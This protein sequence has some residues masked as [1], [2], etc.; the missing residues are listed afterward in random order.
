MVEYG[1]SII[2]L[3][4]LSYQDFKQRQVSVFLL[5]AL[6]ILFSIVAYQVEISW[7]E[8]VKNFVIN[9]GFVAIQI[10]VVKIYF[11]LRN[12]RNERILD[13]Y[14][15]KGDLFFFIVSCL[16]FS[17]AWF[18][19]F[20]IISLIIALLS[21]II[22]NGLGKAKTVEIP[23]AGIMS[24]V[25]VVSIIIKLVHNSFSF[26]DDSYLLQLMNISNQ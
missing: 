12:K 15:G 8:M 25:M 1:I 26:Y 18:I 4:V 5:I 24:L 21:T 22:S 3:C 17:V 23:L 19:P 2:V 20:Y 9:A 10:V 13:T 16:A 7:K 14:I 11:S 6:F